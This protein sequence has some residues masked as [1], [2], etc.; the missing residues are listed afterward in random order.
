MSTAGAND[1]SPE[2][3][4][5]EDLQMLAL[6][7][8]N[9]VGHTC[10]VVVL[11]RT[12]DQAISTADVRDHVAARVARA[13]RLTRR[14][15]RDGD[16]RPAWVADSAFDVAN[17]IGPVA[18]EGRPGHD[19]IPA[20]VGRLMAHQLPRE[21][22]LW[23][24]DVIERVDDDTSV[25]VWRLHHALADGYTAMCLAD[26]V[27]WDDPPAPSA[28]STSHLDLIGPVQRSGANPTHWWK[29]LTATARLYARIPGTVRRELV[30]HH[31]STMFD[32]TSS[33]GRSVA[34][35]VIPLDTLQRVAKTNPAHATVN[36]AL[37]AVITG[38]MRTWLLERGARLGGIRAKIPVS[39]HSS[40][41]HADKLANRDSYFFLD[42]PLGEPDAVQRLLTISRATRDRKQHRDA[43]TI[44]R[45]PFSRRAA[46]WARSRRVFTFNVS[47]VR[48]PTR[49]LSV[50]N[51][52][53]MALHSV[54]EI[55]VHHAIRFAAL[56][57]S[58][59]MSISI[60]A[61]GTDITDVGALRDAMYD[62]V[63]ELVAP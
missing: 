53:V 15:G 30:T 3:L 36:D 29:S 4:T 27:L 44:Y 7:A 18:D 58:G 51:T 35:V 31:A 57:S 42:L 25:L 13:P 63:N 9:V 14:L 61:D 41:A 12:D 5:A 56:S 39:L 19:D 24:L 34:F 11:Q 52:P 6:E 48:G 62:A 20:V 43:E 23:H 55:G 22:P 45:M 54:A 49:R 16:G 32:A 50:L 40:E 33:D 8:G 26:A 59:Q 2:V 10:K 21:R 46:H 38:A 47:N 37:L 1:A 17:H 60:C 28:E